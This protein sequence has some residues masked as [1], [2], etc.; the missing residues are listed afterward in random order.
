MEEKKLRNVILK[1]MTWIQAHESEEGQGVVE[2]GLIVGLVSIAL[3]GVLKTAGTGWINAV[4]S[5][6]NGALGI[7]P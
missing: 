7:T 1:T 6:V 3:A 5:S 2:Y 4:T